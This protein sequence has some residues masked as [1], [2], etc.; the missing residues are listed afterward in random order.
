MEHSGTWVGLLVTS[1]KDNAQTIFYQ[2]WITVSSSNT[3]QSQATIT[4]ATMYIFYFKML[5]AGWAQNAASYN[6]QFAGP[7][8]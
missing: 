5:I 8:G 4:M 1:L 3:I 6:R 2:K 7:F